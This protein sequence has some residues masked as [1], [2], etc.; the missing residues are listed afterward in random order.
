MTSCSDPGQ[1]KLQIKPGLC[2]YNE[3][4]GILSQVFFQEVLTTFLL[5]PTLLLSYLSDIYHGIADSFPLCVK[6]PYQCNAEAKSLTFLF[7]LR[8]LLGVAW[9]ITS[10][11]A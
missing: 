3:L 8:T 6:S 2:L 9:F 5:P 4:Y 11:H 7:C 10:L 1:E